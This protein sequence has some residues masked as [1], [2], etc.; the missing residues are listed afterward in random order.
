MAMMFHTA[1]NKVDGYTMTMAAEEEGMGM[2]VEV[3]MKDDKMEAVFEILAEEEGMTMSME[4]DG[5]YTATNK[6]P[7]GAPG[8]DAAV[9]DLMEMMEALSQTEMLVEPAA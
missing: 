7:V 2:A 4:M 3:T 1:G 5:T 9:M 8:K 6:A